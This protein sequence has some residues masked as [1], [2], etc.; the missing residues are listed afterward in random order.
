MGLFGPSQPRPVQHTRKAVSK[1]HGSTNT[2]KTTNSS[3]ILQQA[4][5]EWGGYMGIAVCRELLETRYHLRLT[6]RSNHLRLTC[7]S[8][9]HGGGVS[10]SPR[11]RARQGKRGE[12]PTTPSL[13][14][15]VGIEQEQTGTPTTE[16]RE[17]QSD[18][19]YRAGPTIARI[20][21]ST[22]NIH[23]LW[24]RPLVGRVEFSKSG[25]QVQ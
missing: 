23:Q 17:N 5:R 6:C 21:R 4:G 10:C 2:S 20:K 13:E 12:K 7:R 1:K 25:T 24:P 19:E 11:D 14:H 22:H 8:N 18:R 16:K 15:L 3:N 9:R